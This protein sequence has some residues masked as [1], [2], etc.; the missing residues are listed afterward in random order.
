MHR[1]ISVYLCVFCVSF[2][3]AWLL[4]CCEHSGVD[5][6]GLKSNY[7]YYYYM[8]YIAPISRIESEALRSLGPIF[9]SALTLLVGSFDPSPM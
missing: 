6:M 7:Y 1:F 5:L 9:F 8:I 3:T 4:Y 2:H